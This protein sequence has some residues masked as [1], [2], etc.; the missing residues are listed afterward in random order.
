MLGN[1]PR[2]RHFQIYIFREVINC[3]FVILAITS[4]VMLLTVFLLI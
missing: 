4:L 2:S 3:N 1:H